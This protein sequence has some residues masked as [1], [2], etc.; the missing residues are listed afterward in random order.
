L[1]PSS[2]KRKGRTI[3]VSK[4]FNGSELPSYLWKDKRNLLF[5]IWK[6]RV[7]LKLKNWKAGGAKIQP[8]FPGNFPLCVGCNVEFLQPFNYQEWFN[9]SI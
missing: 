8:P 7:T 4:L 3:L 1:W 6:N 5:N 9:S 2:C